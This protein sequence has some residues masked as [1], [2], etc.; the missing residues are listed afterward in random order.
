VTAVAVRGMRCS[1]ATSPKEL[2]CDTVFTSLVLLRRNRR[3][4]SN[5]SSMEMLDSVGTELSC[6]R[7]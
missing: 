7:R 6:L 1:K 2:P 3:K 4:Y 5:S